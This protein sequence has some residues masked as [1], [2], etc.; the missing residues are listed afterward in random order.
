[1]F[2]GVGGPDLTKRPKDRVE[3]VLR[4]RFYGIGFTVRG[5]IRVLVQCH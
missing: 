2:W 3:R 4:K 5:S 1:M